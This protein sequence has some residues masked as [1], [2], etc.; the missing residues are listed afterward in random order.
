MVVSIKCRKLTFLYQARLGS[1][2]NIYQDLQES[3]QNHK[4]DLYGARSEIESYS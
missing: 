2:C 4:T 1:F 3:R